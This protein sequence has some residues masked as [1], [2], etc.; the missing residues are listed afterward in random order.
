MGKD[1]IQDHHSSDKAQTNLL[2]RTCEQIKTFLFYSTFFSCTASGT[3]SLTVCIH[4][5]L[6]MF[7][8]A[9]SGTSL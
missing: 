4:A 7:Q 5:H 6:D 9:L 3:A 2:P 1:Q 8:Q